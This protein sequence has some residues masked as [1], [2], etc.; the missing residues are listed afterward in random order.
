LRMLLI[1][2]ARAVLRA[3]QVRQ[4]RRCAHPAAAVGAGPAAAARPQ[5]SRRG[6][7]QQTGPSPRGDDPS[8][9]GLRCAS[10]Q[11]APGRQALNP[12]RG[13]PFSEL[14]GRS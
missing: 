6:P 12:P 5:Q 7:G 10:L 14:P 4:A 1:H 9:P 13:E 3:A 2:G 11:H 8:R